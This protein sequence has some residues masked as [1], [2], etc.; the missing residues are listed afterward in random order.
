M[1]PIIRAVRAKKA[2]KSGSTKRLLSTRYP[3]RR[4][5]LPALQQLTK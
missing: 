1:A 2:A 3:P 5:F 4:T